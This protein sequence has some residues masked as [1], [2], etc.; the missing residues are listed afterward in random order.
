VTVKTCSHKRPVE[1]P[2]ELWI[3]VTDGEW[4]I[5]AFVS[6]AHAAGW[7]GEAPEKRH[8]FRV[9]GTITAE[10]QHVPPVPADYLII[11]VG[12]PPPSGAQPEVDR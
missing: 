3:G 11:P 5:R 4:P 2:D 9:D 8:A 12:A 6:P 1:W 10:V 7:V